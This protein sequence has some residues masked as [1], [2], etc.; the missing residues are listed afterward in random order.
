MRVGLISPPFIPVPPLEYG[1][2]ELF[3]SDLARGLQSL[4]IDVIVYTNAESSVPVER[5]W[6]REVA[7]AHQGR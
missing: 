4:G 3:I 1:G 2:T 5:R 7:V 6:I